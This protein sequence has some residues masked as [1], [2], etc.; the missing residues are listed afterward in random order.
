MTRTI[1]AVVLFVSITATL[2]AAAPVPT[3]PAEQLPKGAT[4]RLGSM[5]Y[6]GPFAPS[7]AFSGDG[8][9]IIGQDQ[10]GQLLIWDSGTGKP[11]PTKFSPPPDLERVVKAR[12]TVSSILVKDR[13]VSLAQASFN[14]QLNSQAIVTDFEGQVVTRCEVEG[15]P[16]FQIDQHRNSFGAAA[17]SLDG[18]Y[19]VT[20][21]D[22]SVVIA[23]DLTS[24]TKLFTLKFEEKLTTRMSISQDG[25]T[26]FLN[27]TGQPLH[28]YEL[29]SGKELPVLEGS[30]SE[31]WQAHT[32]PD[33]KL[34]V[35][36]KFRTNQVVDGKNR[37][38]DVESF[39]VWNG[40]TGKLVESVELGAA[41]YHFAFV[42]ND[43]I[44]VLGIKARPLAPAITTF[45][46]WNLSNFTRDWTVPGRG[47]RIILAPDRKQFLS[48]GPPL[49]L[50]DVASGKAVNQLQ[51]HLSGIGWIAFSEDGKSV[52]TAGE[53]EIK[54]W[55]LKGELKQSLTV[56]EL[57]YTQLA[58]LS[59]ALRGD[60]LAWRGYTE[61]P[62]KP[63]IF[64]WDSAHNAIGWRI[65]AEGGILES[66]HTPDGKHVIITRPDKTRAAAVV[67]VYDGLTGDKIREWT[68]DRPAGLNE[69][70]WSGLPTGDGRYV[71]VGKRDLVSIRESLTGKEI[72]RVATGFEK[73][74]GLGLDSRAEFVVSGNGAK[75][76]VSEG[77]AVEVY[78]VKTGKSLGRRTFKQPGYLSLK[79]SGDGKQLAIWPNT[80][81]ASLFVWNVDERE[82]VLRELVRDTWSAPTCVAFNSD[83]SSLAVGYFDGTALIWDLNAK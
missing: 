53:R 39:Q 68:Y 24:G 43:S 45:S 15:R 2:P 12:G 74:A 21:V 9:R 56:P 70:Q 14:G 23:Y 72:A 26:L 30:D 65:P 36:S 81:S 49:L 28:R 76:A 18:R 60:H 16:S 51:G 25:K 10:A 29:P 83:C 71:V 58:V 41:A 32:S 50:H 69:Y 31:I 3:V 77:G 5:L 40:T 8:K 79:F 33:G 61:D 55:N 11:L 42:E 62:L 7:L 80:R 6:R 20:G 17:V 63:M 52:F 59:G 38:V 4:A 54:T 67:I 44:L 13:V 73:P 75:L 82:S 37:E 48:A 19:L 64:G 66:G 27:R 1:S 35:T 78:D 46:R 57:R 22:A 47:L 34:V